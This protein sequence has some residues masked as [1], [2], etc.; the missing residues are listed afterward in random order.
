MLSDETRCS[1][2]DCPRLASSGSSKVECG[3]HFRRRLA[4]LSLSPE[5]TATRTKAVYYDRESL[6]DTVAPD[7]QE[8]MYDSTD[9]LGFAKTLA[10]GSVV[11]RNRKTGEV[12]RLTDDQVD[13][14]YLGADN[15][16]G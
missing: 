11:H 16:L 10:D 12:E 14:T 5:L 2:P 8:R 7:A 6:A 13:R 4:S 3:P 15:V 1:V 9:G